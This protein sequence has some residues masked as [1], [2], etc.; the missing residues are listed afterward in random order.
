MN[1]TLTTN[2]DARGN[3]RTCLWLGMDVCK[4]SRGNW[5]GKS[6]TV[7]LLNGN[8]N[9][10]ASALLCHLWKEPPEPGEKT[11]LVFVETSE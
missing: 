7:C 3:G 11:E 9:P 6:T 5:K 8:K 10:A 4:D 1:L 2:D